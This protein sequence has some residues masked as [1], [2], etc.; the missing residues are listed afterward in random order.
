MA[1]IKTVLYPTDFSDC[2]RYAFGLATTMARLDKARLIV[3]HVRQD[4]GSRFAYSEMATYL[5]PD[6]YEDWL[7]KVLARF[8]VPDE[9]VTV[10]HQLLDGNPATEILRVADE[11]GTDLIVMG[12]HG[13]TGLKRL[14]LGSIAECVLRKAHCPVI[15]VQLPRQRCQETGSEECC[16]ASVGY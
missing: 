14:V 10:E 1:P 2:S 3:L 15:T 8:Q 4:T 9:D 7:W 16:L 12:T 6:A 5:Q 13:R 11:T